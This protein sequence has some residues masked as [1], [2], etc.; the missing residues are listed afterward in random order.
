MKKKKLT[1]RYS[2]N[3]KFEYSNGYKED[4]TSNWYVYTPNNIHKIIFDKKIKEI[5]KYPWKRKIIKIYSEETGYSIYRI[6]KGTRPGT[7]IANT[8]CLDQPSCFLLVNQLGD[9]TNITISRG[10]KFKFYWNHFDHIVRC[11]FKL[12][13]TSVIL[14]LIAL[15]LTI[16]SISI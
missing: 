11:S 10:S 12:G 4:I 8:I 16:I 9:K 5:P 1:R 7:K 14:G 6:W 13:F 2:V 3:S 15:I